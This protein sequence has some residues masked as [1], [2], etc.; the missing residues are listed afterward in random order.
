MSHYN[1]FILSSASILVPLFVGFYHIHKLSDRYLPFFYFLLFFSLNEIITITLLTYFPGTLLYNC[2]LYYLLEPLLIFGIFQRW[3]LFKEK[4]GVFIILYS[5]LIICWCLE[6]YYSD[7]ATFLPF[8]NM[9][10]GFVIVII[11]ISMINKIL[12]EDLSDLIENPVFVISCIF[13]IFFIYN[14]VHSAFWLPGLQQDYNFKWKVYT[15][16]NFINLVCNLGYTLAI[17]QI[18]K[19]AKAKITC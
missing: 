19:R 3:G 17:L 7:F 2:D 1:F 13:L 15:V 8:F 5:F 16:L 12:S 9:I 6:L 11:S 10:Y 4:K 14:I 18:T